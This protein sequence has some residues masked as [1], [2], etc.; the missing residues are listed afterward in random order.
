MRPPLAWAVLAASS[1]IVLLLS[2]ASVPA[3]GGRP[4][5]LVAAPSPRATLA[6]LVQDVGGRGASTAPER[7]GYLHKIDSHLQDVAASRLGAGSAASAAIAA[8]RQGVTLS[9]EGD[10]LTDIY[11]DGDAARAAGLR[12]LGMRVTAVSDRAPQRMVEGFLPP[13]R[14]RRPRRSGRRGRSSL[15]LCG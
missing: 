2:G 13:G 10:A 3:A 9:R 1:V 7:Y 6:E 8:R 14:S 12:A 11:V 4:A 5:A 15:R